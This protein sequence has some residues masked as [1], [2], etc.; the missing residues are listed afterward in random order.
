MKLTAFDIPTMT[1]S[2]IEAVIFAG[3][4]SSEFRAMSDYLEDDAILAITEQDHLDDPLK[5]WAW[6]VI[7]GWF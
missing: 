6:R 1:S 4:S 3:A 5:E 7:D 2:E